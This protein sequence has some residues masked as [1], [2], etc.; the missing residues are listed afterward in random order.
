MIR[1]EAV[2]FDPVAQR[3]PRSD[4]RYP[5]VDAG[6]LAV[7]ALLLAMFVSPLVLLARSRRIAALAGAGV[8]GHVAVW[9]ALLALVLPLVQIA[10]AIRQVGGPAVRSNRDGQRI[11]G[12]AGRVARVHA[13]LI[14][15]L[16][17]FAVAVSALQAAHASTRWTVAA[18]MM[19]V[20]ARLVHALSYMLGVTVIR[21]AAFY[22][23]I[24][25]TSVIVGSALL[26]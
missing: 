25:A 4:V 22:A 23:G 18:A 15:S 1:V 10:L 17:P 3:R 2:A 24:V 6:A 9:T 5:I 7:A 12:T 16:L 8:E 11:A 21:S 26:A 19:Y 14:E 20:A 13:N